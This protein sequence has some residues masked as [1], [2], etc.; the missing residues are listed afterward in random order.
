M[1]KPNSGALSKHITCF[2]SW[3]HSRLLSD[4]NTAKVCAACPS[5]AYPSPNPYFCKHSPRSIKTPLSAGGNCPTFQIR[6]KEIEYVPQPLFNEQ[7]LRLRFQWV[8]YSHLGCWIVVC[9]NISCLIKVSLRCLNICFLK[10][11][12]AINIS[13][14]A[15]IQ[16]STKQQWTIVTF[17]S[18]G[19]KSSK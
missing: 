11:S 2:M 19:V 12:D 18:G 8:F 14:T 15:A 6:I 9:K 16:Y 13:S 7:R 17:N 5:F 1:S 3:Q 4:H 10:W